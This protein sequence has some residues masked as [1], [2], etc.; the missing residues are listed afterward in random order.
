[1]GE[2]AN[3][4]IPRWCDSLRKLD[5]AVVFLD[6]YG[7]QVRWSTIEA[8]ANT[9]KI[10]L[11]LL[12][13]LGQA[14]M[15]LLTRH[16]PPPEAWQER[17]TAIFGTDTWL[18]EFYR[19]VSRPTLF[20]DEVAIERNAEYPEVLKWF[21]QERLKPIFAEVLESPFVLKNSR[22]TPLYALCFAATNRKG[23]PVAVKIAR[24]LSEKLTREQPH[25]HRVD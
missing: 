9:Q 15:R 12:F 11:W 2:D 24:D 10:D 18:T 17:L 4:F 1:V 5:R 19:T 21:V 22:N 23:A 20:G 14:V 6:P 16:E 3:T 7:M 13:P 8:I 25:F